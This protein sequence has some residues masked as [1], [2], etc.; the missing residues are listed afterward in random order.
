MI[1]LYT[2]ESGH[3]PGE[4]SVSLGLACTLYDHIMAD[5]KMFGKDGLRFK[6]WQ[7]V[8][9]PPGMEGRTEYIGEA[10]V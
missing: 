10:D 4:V 6:Y 3:K 8:P 5:L 2:D 1:V 9:V 7:P